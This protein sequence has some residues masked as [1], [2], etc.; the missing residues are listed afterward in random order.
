[1]LTKI[2]GALSIGAGLVMLFLTS[3]EIRYQP[4]NFTNMA[5]LI[6]IILILVGI[7]LLK[8]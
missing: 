8:M 6:G 1:M 5:L 3:G 4:G 2:L 7:F